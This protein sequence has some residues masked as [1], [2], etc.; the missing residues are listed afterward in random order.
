MI[1]FLEGGLGD[2]VA[3]VAHALIIHKNA[4]R[5]GPIRFWSIM[6]SQYNSS[7]PLQNQGIR[8]LH[9]G[10]LGDLHRGLTGQ[11]TPNSFPYRVL[12]WVTVRLVNTLRRL[13]N[14]FD[15]Q[16]SMVSRLDVGQN[17]ATPID[18]LTREGLL[19]IG[20]PKVL[21]P[22]NPSADYLFLAEQATTKKI[23]G[24]HI[25]L[26]DITGTPYHLS[27]DYY[28]DGVKDCLASEDYDDVWLFSDDP[29][30]AI[31]GLPHATRVTNISGQYSLSVSEDLCLLSRCH[32]MVLSASHFS[33]MAYLLG[34]REGK[35]IFP[36]TIKTTGRT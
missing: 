5:S 2:Q 3:R 31:A 1:V 34:D 32:S 25:R 29:D 4:G 17:L 14:R 26:T 6:T 7:L 22:S 13:F 30:T 15:T 28:S 35:I 24:V 10:Q 8:S 23:L 9:W 36:H 19:E 33:T 27:G 21:E 12:R 11:D 16:A 18:S 20:F